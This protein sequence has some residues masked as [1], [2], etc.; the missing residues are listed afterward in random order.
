M[1]RLLPGL[2]LALLAVP[3]LAQAPAAQFHIREVEVSVTRD[4]KVIAHEV[5]RLPV[6]PDSKDGSGPTASYER[7]WDEEVTLACGDGEAWNEV[8]SEI[9]FS[10]SDQYGMT[11]FNFAWQEDTTLSDHKGRCKGTPKR[12]QRHATVNTSMALDDGQPQTFRG[13]HGIMVTVTARERTN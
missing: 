4:G 9:E 5:L 11:M 12:T 6:Y 2:L 7:R 1:A 3:T 8:Q 10:A 13:D